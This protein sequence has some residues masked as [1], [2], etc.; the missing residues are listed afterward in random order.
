MKAP[1]WKQEGEH[2]QLLTLRLN[3]WPNVI[4]S[5]FLYFH[6]AGGSCF[7]APW[8]QFLPSFRQRCPRRLSPTRSRRRLPN[9]R[10]RQ[11]SARIFWVSLRTPRRNPPERSLNRPSR[12][13][14]IPRP[15]FSRR[16][17]AIP[18]SAIS[19]R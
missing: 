4:A 9:P 11:N 19:R 5:L 17:S 10:S 18:P 1:C 3:I 13:A 12:A 2:D 15:T 14:P 6:F 8:L 16:N 7:A